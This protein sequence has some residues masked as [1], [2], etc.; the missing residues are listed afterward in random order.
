MSAKDALSH[1]WFSEHLKAGEGEHYVQ[2]P[3]LQQSTKSCQIPQ[4]LNSKSGQK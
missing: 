4:P 2:A 3:R 1:K